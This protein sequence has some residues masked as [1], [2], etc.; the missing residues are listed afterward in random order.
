MSESSGGHNNQDGL[1][2]LLGRRAD[3]LRV[4]L[5]VEARPVQE[6]D[7][8]FDASARLAELAARHRLP[9]MYLYQEY[10]KASGLMAPASTI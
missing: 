9:A 7:A 6:F 8:A 4:T 1:P 10:V 3:R 5:L 2:S